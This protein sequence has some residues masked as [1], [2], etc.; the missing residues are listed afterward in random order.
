MGWDVYREQTFARQ[1]KLGVVP[2]DTKLTP[3]PEELPAWDSL[4]AD[5]KR[6]FA[7][8]MEVFAAFTAQ[9]D[10]EMGRL[11]DVVR[12]CPDARQHADHLHR[13]RQRRHRRGRPRRLAQREPVLQRRPGEVA[14]QPQ[15][16][17]RARRAEALQPLPGR[18]G[19]GDEHAVPVD[20][21]DRLALRRRA[22]SAGRLV[23]GADQGQGRRARPVPPRD[24]HRPDDLRSCRHHASD[25]CSTASRR[26]RSRASASPTR[27]T[28]PRPRA[29]A[30]RSTSRCSS[31]AA[32]T[33]TAGWRPPCPF[34][35]WQSV[36][37]AFDPDKPKWE[38]YNL[39]EDFSQANDL[40]AANPE[41]LRQLQDLWWAEAARYNVLPLDWR[42]TER[43]NAELMGRPSLIARPD[44]ADLLP[45]HGR[46][47]PEQLAAACSTNRGPSPP[48]SKCPKAAA[49]A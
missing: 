28:T 24:R 10:H 19:V 27:S 12:L 48:T 40:A 1:K 41:K 43:F 8:M 49:T 29:G 15:A 26:S 2:Q 7:R 39:D 23:A 37:G 38:L 3:R 21:A 13:R 34:A 17:R 32:S 16:H 20:Q 31:T 4:S 46:A 22:Q 30:P 47:A 5:Q 45:G 18:L 35:P 44:E 25:R 11:L 9:T 14:G 42:A 33:T 36:R 6:L